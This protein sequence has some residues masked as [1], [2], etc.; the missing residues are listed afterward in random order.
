MGLREIGRDGM[1]WIEVAEDKEQQLVAF[2]LWVIFI[3]YFTSEDSSVASTSL[4]TTVCLFHYGINIAVYYRYREHVPS[5]AEW[6]MHDKAKWGL[7]KNSRPNL[8]TIK[9]PA[10]TGHG[11][12][13]KPSASTANAAKEILFENLTNSKNGVSWNVTQCGSG[14]NRDFW[15]M[16]CLHHQ[17][18]RIRQLGTTLAVIV[19]PDVGE[20]MFF[21]NVCSYKS[22]TTSHPVRKH[23]SYSPPWKPQILPNGFE[24][25]MFPLD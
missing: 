8:P 1:D 7:R 25:R 11:K 9:V 21:L 6:R 18:E 22:H 3:S 15:R 13:T 2:L 24:F 17:N 19:E 10:W 4:P 12:T 5:E 20:D 23:S 16:Y 14:K